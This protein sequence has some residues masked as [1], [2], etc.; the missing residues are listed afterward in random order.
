MPTPA[1][2]AHRVA[3]TLPTCA[4]CGNSGSS[5]ATSTRLTTTN[6]SNSRSTAIEAIAV[7]N[8]TRGVSR[9]RANARASSPARGPDLLEGN[10]MQR[11]P[12]QGD[13][14]DDP[15]DAAPI[16]F[17]REFLRAALP[18]LGG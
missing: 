9:V 3:G 8:D 6:P 18:P 1:R 5:I 2:A 7:A 4:P 15:E 10:A 13:A 17:H 11:P 14:Q 16:Q 12:Q